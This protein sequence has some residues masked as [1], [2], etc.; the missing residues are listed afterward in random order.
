MLRQGPQSLSESTTRRDVIGMNARSSAAWVLPV[1]L[2]VLCAL[3][4]GLIVRSFRPARQ[5]SISSPETP[6]PLADPRSIDL[7]E[8][9]DTPASDR[10]EA[11]KRD[12]IHVKATENQL[13]R[14]RELEALMSEHA[15]AGKWK[16]TYAAFST[17]GLAHE[18]E[19]M[20]LAIQE[21]TREEFDSRFRTGQFDV[22][23]T[24]GSYR[25]DGYE[26]LDVAEIRFIGNGV[27]QKS[28][29][30]I[31]GFEEVYKLR[32]QAVWLFEEERNRP[33]AQ[34]GK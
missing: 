24:D 29:L 12:P 21:A 26:P 25:S 8:S 3:L 16:E 27:I 20:I 14:R 9:A 7:L 28:V 2:F 1:A 23:S 31:Q 32:A 19:A 10:G 4:A 11:Q 22:V 15:R 34:A 5:S 13:A 33:A 18:R 30:P 17:A 6:A